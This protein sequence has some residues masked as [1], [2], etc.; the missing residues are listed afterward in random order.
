M[1]I[2]KESLRDMESRMRKT[3]MI[4]ELLNEK[5]DRIIQNYKDMNLM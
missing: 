1:E 3:K 5:I 2:M 4:S